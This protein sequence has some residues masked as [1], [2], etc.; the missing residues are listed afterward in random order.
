MSKKFQIQKIL[1]PYDFSE[2]AELTLEHATF[3][4]KLH[5]AEIH[6]LHVI[7]SYSFTSA[8]SNAFTKSQ[9]DYETKVESSVK[10]RLKEIADKLHH[11][12][13]MNVNFGVE[14]GK[15]YK[16]IIQVA[17]QKNIDIIVMGT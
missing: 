2:T 12:S 16:K 13:G 17:E 10:L 8:I 3:M 11:N 4:A 6:L 14:V 7:E 15:I 9:S 1:I 5:K